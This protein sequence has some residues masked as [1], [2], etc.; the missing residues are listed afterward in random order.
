MKVNHLHPDVQSQLEVWETVRD[1]FEG[2]TAIKRKGA[3]YLLPLSGHSIH[4]AIGA[5][6]DKYKQRALFLGVVS[7]TV[8]GLVGT[9]FYKRPTIN[10]PDALG[11]DEDALMRTARDAVQEQLLA[12]R[13]GL[14][15]ERG[16]DEDSFNPPYL[17]LY[18]AE[19]IINYMI[20]RDKKT[21]EWVVLTEVVYV[22]DKEDPFHIVERTRYRELGLDSEGYYYQRVWEKDDN[23]SMG[24]DTKFNLIST[25]YPTRNGNKLDFVPFVMMNNDGVGAKVQQPPVQ[26]I[27][28]ANIK[29][30]NVDAMHSA[31]LEKSALMQPWVHGW[32]PKPGD[33]DKTFGSGD[34]WCFGTKQNFDIGILE[35]SGAAFSAYEREKG[36][37]ESLMSSMGARIIEPN[38]RSVETAEALRIREASKQASLTS[39]VN[40]T[41]AGFQMALDFAMR[42]AGITTED[43]MFN[44]STDLI[45][46]R[47]G[48][49]DIAV[50]LELLL[51]NKI[52]YETFW[53][54]MRQGEVAP[55]GVS[56]EEELERIQEYQEENEI[57]N[58][59]AESA[60]TALANQPETEQ[61]Q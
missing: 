13:V 14:L 57:A 45:N 30:Y 61:E 28:E 24:T 1:C 33:K 59:F 9:A 39:I 42:W 22:R 29:H 25:I 37:L 15:V 2:Q 36:R 53:W 8:N 3:K 46:E 41:S 35:P 50:L 11:M 7:R 10:I 4:G 60:G 32:S 43:A 17:V 49:R 40:A 20:S 27:A 18:T 52:S 48:H 54:N 21:V 26:E 47:L 56:A 5:E 31:V 55:E 44:L 51:A 12:A 23:A 58:F 34:L 16:E 19:E 6:Y 38:R